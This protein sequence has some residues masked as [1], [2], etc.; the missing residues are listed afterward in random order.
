KM[1]QLIAGLRIEAVAPDT[2]A[3]LGRSSFTQGLTRESLALFRAAHLHYP[4]SF[5]IN[6]DLA[7]ACMKL[8]PPQLE[9]AVRH[10]TAALAL[11]P[12][13][14]FVCLNLGAVLINQG[15]WDAALT[16]FSKALELKPDLAFAHNNVGLVLRHQGK[17]EEAEAALRHAIKL[18]PD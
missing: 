2:L 4:E 7:Y 9:E 1:R 6:S 12:K 17:I 18:L 13:N 15:K 5:E 16:V 3:F 8:E 14:A 11:R 10:Y